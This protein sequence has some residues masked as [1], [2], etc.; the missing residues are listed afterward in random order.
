MRCTDTTIIIDTYFVDRSMLMLCEPLTGS[1]HY[2]PS[3]V[4]YIFG[5]SS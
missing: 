2:F 3:D 1:V 5:V 4:G